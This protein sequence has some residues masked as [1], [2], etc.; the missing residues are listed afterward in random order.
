VSDL[1]VGLIHA[2]IRAAQVCACLVIVLAVQ[3]YGWWGL[4]YVPFV[5]LIVWAWQVLYENIP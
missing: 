3:S 4:L 5:A 2:A 1:Q